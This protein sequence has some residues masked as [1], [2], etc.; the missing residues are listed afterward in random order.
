MRPFFIKSISGNIFALYHSPAN[1]A[2]FKRNILFI[3]PFAEELNRSRHMINRQAR[4]FTESGYGVLV[5]D[6]YGTGDSEGGFGD[7]TIPIWQQDIL[8]AVEWLSG[9]SDSPPILWAMRS[10]ALIS[11]D[12]VQ[13]YP[14]L[15]DR[16]ILWSPTGNGKKFITQYMRIKLAADVTGRSG[17]TKVTINDLWA[18][19]AAGQNLEIAGYALSPEMARGFSALSLNNMILPPEMHI[20]WIET[21]LMDPAK[22]SPASLGIIDTWNKND[23]QVSAMAVNDVSFWTL[24]EPEMANDYIEQTLKLIRLQ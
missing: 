10:G 7:A 12:L 6:L 1:D 16:M 24:Q 14:D 22:L 13:Q 18:Q 17:D 23:L 11:T 5:V 15:T 8:A 4:A 20:K 21:S 3:P 19:F 2:P 9:I